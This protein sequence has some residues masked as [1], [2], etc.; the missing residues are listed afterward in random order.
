MGVFV[1]V[2]VLLTILMGEDEQLEYAGMV[3]TAIV[4][5]LMGAVVIDSSKHNFPALRSH[6]LATVGF[7]SIG[8]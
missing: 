5:W 8:M 6:D 3:G 7:S 2:S 4:L 1:F